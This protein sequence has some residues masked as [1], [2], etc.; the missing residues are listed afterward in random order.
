[1][2]STNIGSLETPSNAVQLGEQESEILILIG[3]QE[4]VDRAFYSSQLD[5]G[6]MQT[7]TNNCEFPGYNRIGMKPDKYN[8]HGFGFAKWRCKLSD[9]W[10]RAETPAALLNFLFDQ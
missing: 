1:M 4:E 3:L 6:S 10:I 2:K 8:L 7:C 9:F 5:L